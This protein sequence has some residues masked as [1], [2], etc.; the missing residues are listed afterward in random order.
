MK[1]IIQV[2]AIFLLL[3]S[4]VI[5]LISYVHSIPFT[6]STFDISLYNVIYTLFINTFLQLIFYVLLS[7]TIVLIFKEMFYSFVVLVVL[8][9]FMLPHLNRYL[10]IPSG[11]NSYGFLINGISPYY[12]TAILSVYIFIEIVTIYYLLNK[13]DFPN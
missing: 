3:F 9:F 4:L 2:I 6:G 13:R 5:I 12:I 1:K 8:S 11:L 10:I 7:I